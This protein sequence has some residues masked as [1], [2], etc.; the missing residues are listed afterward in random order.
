MANMTNPP[1]LNVLTYINSARPRMTTA[2]KMTADYILAHPEDVVNCTAAELAERTLVSEASVI[3]LCKHL[4][5]KGY[6][7]LKIKL[8]GELGKG[9]DRESPVPIG[10]RKEDSAEQTIQKV[11]RME[12]EDIRFSL[13]M[14]DA[15][16][17]ARCLELLCQCRQL[18]FFGIG[19]SSIV[20]ASA[21]E[22]FLHYGKAAMAEQDNTTQLILANTLGEND[23]AFCISMSGESFVPCEAAKIAKSR[24]AAT[25]ALTQTPGSSLTTLCDCVVLSHRRVGVTDDLGTVS[26]IVQLAIM[27][28]L[29]IAYA[30]RNWDRTQ[31]TAEEN[32]QRF[33]QIQF[34]P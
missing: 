22:H 10:I 8:A 4:G 25:V 17:A 31:E 9:L 12:Y 15:E 16:S 32:R 21:K 27:D 30:A 2:F 34:K 29:A 33:R 14:L 24:G 23:V 18:A 19:S 7:D 26:R 11:L 1:A 6:T 20:A 3:R 5:F 28:A 13:D